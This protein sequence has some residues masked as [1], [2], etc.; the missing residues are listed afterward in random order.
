VPG[1]EPMHGA[2][3]DR[4]TALAQLRLNL[5]Q[6]DVPLLGEQLLDEV[7]VRLDPARVAVTAARLGNGSAM[8]Q[9]K[10]PPADR[11]RDADIKMGCSRSATHAAVDRSDNPIPQVL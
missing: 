10:A 5:D 4:N 2:D 1:E 7:A 9:R 6:S 11:A 8:L 3:A